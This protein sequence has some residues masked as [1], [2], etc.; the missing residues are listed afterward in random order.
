[1]AHAQ[2]LV[3]SMLTSVFGIS[4]GIGTLISLHSCA[5]MFLFVH[6][7]CIYMPIQALD[8]CNEAGTRYVEAI[9]IGC[10]LL[11]DTYVPPENYTVR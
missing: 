4:D 9:N 5:I 3:D 11:I 1:M 7:T 2:V 8:N 6:L 10:A